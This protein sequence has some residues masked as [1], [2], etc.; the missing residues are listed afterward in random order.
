MKEDER[1]AK[2]REK[3]QKRNE[4]SGDT[5]FDSVDPQSTAKS[6]DTSQKPPT[7]PE[8]ES[9]K[10]EQGLQAAHLRMVP[11]QGCEADAATIHTRVE[12][13]ASADELAVLADGSYTH[14]PRTL[15]APSDKYQRG[16]VHRSWGS[17]V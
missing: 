6:T 4:D 9:D 1:K 11:V 14:G 15:P 10:E 12:T 5:G 17:P 2:L 13:C 8:T 16:S 7:E 3:F